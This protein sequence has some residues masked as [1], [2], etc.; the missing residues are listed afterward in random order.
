MPGPVM[1]VIHSSGWPIENTRSVIVGGMKVADI[2]GV[3]PG[4]AGG[5]MVNAHP[6]TVKGADEI[7]TGVPMIVTRGFKVVGWACP[8]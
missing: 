6:T 8:P 5:G 1:L 7:G 2:H 4:P 3:G